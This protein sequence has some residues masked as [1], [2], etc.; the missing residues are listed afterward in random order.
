MNPRGS[1]DWL[2]Y[3]FIFTTH[4]PWGSC[5]VFVGGLQKTWRIVLRRADTESIKAHTRWHFDSDSCQDDLWFT[6]VSHICHI[7]A[8]ISPA[9]SLSSTDPSSF[10]TAHVG[11][12]GTKF[13]ILPSLQEMPQNIS[14]SFFSLVNHGS[15]SLLAKWGNGNLSTWK[16]NLTPHLAMALIFFASYHPLKNHLLA[17]SLAM[18]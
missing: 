4:K 13:K 18:T 14:F 2:I 12:K 10:I 8:G 1:I 5:T 11:R 15:S 9:W 7:C 6:L 16:M 17:F 3:C